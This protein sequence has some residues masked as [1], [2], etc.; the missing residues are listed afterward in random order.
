MLGGLL[1]GPFYSSY[2]LYI[3]RLALKSVRILRIVAYPVC[4][5]PYKWVVSLLSV[6]V[7][8]CI[9]PHISQTFI[10]FSFWRRGFYAEPVF[11]VPSSFSCLSCYTLR[12]I[13]SA[14]SRF[15]SAPS[16]S[17]YYM[18]KLILLVSFSSLIIKISLL[19]RINYL[20]FYSYVEALTISGRGVSILDID[21]RILASTWDTSP[22]NS[23]IEKKSIDKCKFNLTY[24]STTFHTSSSRI[25]CTNHDQTLSYIFNHAFFDI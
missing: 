4:N 15:P 20:S 7:F 18:K 22:S 19:S 23:S 16:L 8:D 9:A 5:L 10:N 2:F 12:V 13:S 25:L 24:L 11:P 6:S 14:Y 1:G 3:Y 21:F 17:A